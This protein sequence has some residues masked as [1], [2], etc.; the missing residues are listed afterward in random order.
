MQE[1]ISV[2]C[3]SAKHHW[4]HSQGFC[5]DEGW[6]HPQKPRHVDTGWG[7]HDQVGQEYSGQ[8]AGLL[9]EL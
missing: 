4:C 2:Y 8:Q 3:Y 7:T 5:F 6:M 9:E 1:G